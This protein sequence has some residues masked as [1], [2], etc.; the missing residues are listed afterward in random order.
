MI[1]KAYNI[2]TINVGASLVD[3]MSDK[4]KEWS[5]YFID[6]VHPTD[7]GYQK[8]YDCLEEFLYNSLVFEDFSNSEL[9]HS[10]PEIQSDH[11]FDGNRTSLFGAEMQQYVSSVT[12][13][14]YNTALYYGPDATPH[15]GYYNCSKETSGAEITFRFSG[16]EF[17]IWTN[18]Y[19]DSQVDISIDGGTQKRVI[20][21]SHAPTTL[22]E[23]IESGEHTI[24]IKPVTFGGSTGEMKIG[25]V[26]FRDAAKQT[27]K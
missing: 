16:T 19:N 8:Y 15:Y 13:F 23:N 6:I 26:F 17:A 27:V 2:P 20:C 14:T 3:S 1:A 25:A 21:D 7:A 18:F 12:G 24:T 11:L 22:V 4:E 9:G 5:T 10:M